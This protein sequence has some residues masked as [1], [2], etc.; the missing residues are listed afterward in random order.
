MTLARLA[1]AH[2]ADTI[3][4]GSAQ[5]VLREA[6]AAIPL[7]D[8]IDF[9]KERGRLEKELAKAQSEIAKIDTKLNNAEFVARAPEEV[10]DEQKE[11]RAEAAALA[12]RLGQ[13]LAML[14]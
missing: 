14:G 5:F 2:T 13:A 6:T 11:R 9:A 7:G 12:E 1:S 3:P 8:V 10:V 4:Q